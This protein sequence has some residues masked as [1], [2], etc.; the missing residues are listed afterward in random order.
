M[1]RK[2]HKILVERLGNGPYKCFFCEG[3]IDVVWDGKRFVY[4]EVGRISV[5]HLNGNHDDDRPENLDI[6]HC[7]CH[8]RHHW[9]NKTHSLSTKEKMS[10]ARTGR[11]CPEGCSCGLHKNGSRKCLPGCSCKRH[12]NY[13]PNDHGEKIKKAWAEGRYANR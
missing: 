6:A 3:S 4:G 11:R 1:P 7:G 2:Y 12:A 8:T 9:K 10:L 5:H 13:S